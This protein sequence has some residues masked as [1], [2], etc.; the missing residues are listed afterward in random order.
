METHIAGAKACWRVMARQEH[1]RLRGLP[2]AVASRTPCHSVEMMPFGISDLLLKFGRSR[3]EETDFFQR[4][5]EKLW[6]KIIIDFSRSLLVKLLSLE[7]FEHGK[8]CYLFLSAFIYSP[9]WINWN[10]IVFIKILRAC[11]LLWIKY[12][13]L[14][15]PINNNIDIDIF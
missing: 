8:T 13:K 5:L 9:I 14:F 7:I 15:M 4:A 11:V 6:R 3:R 10:D 12:K 2:S 1:T